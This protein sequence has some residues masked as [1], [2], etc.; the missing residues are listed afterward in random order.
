MA[1][2]YS[3]SNVTTFGEKN[4]LHVENELEHTDLYESYH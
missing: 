1:F 3:Q 4:L 2:E